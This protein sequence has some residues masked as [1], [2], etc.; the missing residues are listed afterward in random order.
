[1]AAVQSSIVLLHYCISLMKGVSWSWILSDREDTCFPFGRTF[2]K[3]LEY[4]V[5]TYHAIVAL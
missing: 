5:F 1:M 3:K 2:D 4:K